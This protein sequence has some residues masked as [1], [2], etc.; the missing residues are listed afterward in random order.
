M[1][2]TE[3][4]WQ[5]LEAVKDPEIPVVSVVE[6]GIVRQVNVDHDHV[7]VQM[8]P[9]F[10]GCPALQVMRDEI[11]AEVRRVGAAEVTVETILSPPWSTDWITEEARQKLRAFGLAPPPRHGGNLAVTFFEV[12]ACPYCDSNNTSVKNT[13][14]STLCRAIYYCNDCQQPFEQFKAL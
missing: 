13:F 6:M 11:E 9:T 8:T 7:R 12:V 3:Q 1:I 2:T 4:V 5:A 10:S 14:G